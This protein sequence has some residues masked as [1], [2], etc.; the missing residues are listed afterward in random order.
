[1]LINV[2]LCYEVGPFVTL[3]LMIVYTFGDK[4]YAMWEAWRTLIVDG[5]MVAPCNWLLSLHPSTSMDI[6]E[7]F[8][9]FEVLKFVPRTSVPLMFE[10]FS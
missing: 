4:M 9:T 10:S 5:V 6:L 2:A 1:M 3:K 7:A 8:Y